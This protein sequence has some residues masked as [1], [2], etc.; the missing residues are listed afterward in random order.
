[1]KRFT[2][3][4]A[5]AALLCVSAAPGFAAEDK[6]NPE[7]RQCSTEYVVGSHLPKRVCSTA[8]EREAVRKASQDKMANLRQHA[9][10]GGTRLGGG[11]N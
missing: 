5:T 9:R 6:K 10:A 3:L 11:P 1:M 7:G 8:A 4:A 2:I